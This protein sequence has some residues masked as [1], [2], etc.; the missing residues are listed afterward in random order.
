MVSGMQKLRPAKVRSALHRRWFE[1][2]LPRTELREA[3]GLVHVGDPHYGGWTI[4][5]ELVRPSSICYCVGA[6][7]DISFDLELIR[8]YGVTVR[9]FDPVAD[10]V[11]R[12]RED[13][14]DEPSFTIH[15]A[16]IAGSD[17]PLRMQLTHDPGSGSVSP[18]GLYDS[19]DYVEVPG[20]TLASLMDELGD[21]QIELLKLDIEGGEFDV[22]P[23]LDLRALGVRIFATQMHHN[24]SVA[25]ARGLIAKL[26]RDGYDAVACVPAVKL[27]FV[28]RDLLQG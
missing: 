20:R 24:G 4:P 13:A 26:R 2:Q 22:I 3:P 5:G 25:D 11:Q 28:R 9:A 12:A 21:E 10:Y 27:T 1:R 17:G 15:Q 23:T 14:G 6:G 19:H 16:A 18:A 7:G 8:R